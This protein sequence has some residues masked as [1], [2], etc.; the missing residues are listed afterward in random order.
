MAADNGIIVQNFIGGSYETDLNSLSC[1]LSD[2]LYLEKFEGDGGNVSSILRS[3]EGTTSAA[4]F[5]VSGVGCRG[6]YW[7]ST[8]PAP[9][10]EP[11][12][13][14]GFNNKVYRID[15]SMQTHLIG[16][17]GDNSTTLKFAESGG[18]NSHLCVVDGYNLF[19]CPLS[20]SDTE[21]AFQTIS[22][23]SIPGTEDPILP[24]QIAFTGGRIV[25]NSSVSD[26]FFYTDLYAINGS[27]GT[28]TSASTTIWTSAISYPTSGSTTS[29]ITYTSAI[30]AY[31]YT[32]ASMLSAFN[33]DLN[34]QKAEN[35]SDFINGLVAVNGLMWIFGPRSYQIYQVQNEQYNPFITVDTAGSQIGC[36]A[37]KSIVTIG[38]NVFWL[39]SSNAGENVIYIGNGTSNIQRIS[40]N[41][42]ERSISCMSDSTDAI[43]QTWTR[44]GHT[45]YAITFPTADKTFVYDLS[46][47]TWHNRN[48]RD[49]LLNIQHLWE[50]QYATLAYGKII[51]GTYN[52]QYLVYLDEDKFTEYDGR[53]I[54]RTRI[55]PVIISNFSDVILNEFELEIGT[56]QTTILT[57]Q[58]SN[59]QCMLQVSTDGGNTF[60]NEIWKSLGK[61]GQYYWRTKWLGFGKGRLFVLKV[62]ISD[63]VKTII[64]SA[65]T[66]W[67]ECNAF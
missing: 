8:G 36:K 9:Y 13:Y 41:A 24:T 58:G 29:A 27:L 52:G 31:E 66:R 59:P 42:I 60:G 35:T 19:V 62:S 11:Q 63:P 2:N 48:T 53:P 10:Y 28:L 51:F 40:T 6:L 56:G 57:G 18:T 38:N 55:S 30:S 54:V 37:P 5:D 1:Q 3:I 44:N 61:T 46:T 33:G 25:L 45:F 49:R 32:T 20:A 15:S 65:K 21:L 47:S 34:F 23:P 17:V 22:L 12:L 43:G 26:F 50:P 67:T 64:M 39:G 4:Q 7:S 16:T 14:A